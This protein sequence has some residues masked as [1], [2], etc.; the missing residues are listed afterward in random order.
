MEAVRKIPDDNSAP[1]KD[2][3][4]VVFILK[5][6]LQEGKCLDW[7]AAVADSQSSGLA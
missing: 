7:K 6:L 5:V 2:Y 4:E 3:T 1:D